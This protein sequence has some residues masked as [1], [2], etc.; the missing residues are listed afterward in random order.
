MDTPLHALIV[1]ASEDDV[2]LIVQ[3]LRRSGYDPIYE[4]IDTAAAMSTALDRQTWDVII[5]DY[6]VLRASGPGALASLQEKG[7]DLPLIVVSSADGEDIAVASIKA[8]AH[9]YV[10]KDNLA[11][12]GAAL[13]RELHEAEGR[14][15]RRRAEQAL[16]QRTAQLEAM[17]E[18]S[19]ELAAQLDLDTLLHSIVSRAIELLGGTSGGLYLYRPEQDALEWSMAVGRTEAFIG[20]VLHRGEGLSGKVWETGEL[21]IVDDYGHWEGRASAYDGV[22]V[23]AAVAAPIRWGDAFLGA[24]NVSSEAVGAFS[25]AHAELLSLL[26]TQAAIAIR[27]AQLYEEAQARSRYLETLQGINAT[28]RST[29]PLKEVLDTIV[30]GAGEALHYVGCLIAI[31]DAAGERLALGAA[32]GT[33]LLSA[34][35]SLTGFKMDAFR[36]PLKTEANPIART[37]LSGELQ[38]WSRVPKEIVLGVVPR[39]SARLAPA[40]ERATGAGLIACVPLRGVAGVVGL[41]IV[42]SPREQLPTEERAMLLG[43]ADQAGLAIDNARLYDE[44]HRRAERLA[45]VNHVARAVGTTL[46]LEDLLE[47]VYQEI[48]LIFQADAFFIALY[49]DKA[50]ELDFRLQID[51][52]IRQA[53][54]R[55]PVGTGLTSLVVAEQKPVLV[56]DLEQEQDRLPQPT[57]WG[58]MK[59]PGSWLGVP[60]KVGER[61]VGVICVQAYRSHAYDGEDQLLLS[62]IADQVAVAVEKARLYQTLHDSEV[63][64]RVL[65]SSIRSPVL[66]LSEDMT[67]LY[68]NDAYAGFVGKS[69]VELEAENLLALFPEFSKMRS[70]AAYMRVLETGEAERVEGAY[71]ERHLRSWVYRTPWGILAIGEDITEQRRAEREIAERQQYLEG[72]LASAPDAIVTLDA[73][74]RIVD[75]SAGAER[76]F[77]YTRDQVFGRNLDHLIT[78]PEVL[79]EATGLTRVVVS[80]EA[81]PP[82][83]AVR[84]RK[85]GSP[86]QVI[87]AGSPIL[88]EGKLIGIVAVYT[89]ISER[90]QA[91]AALRESEEKYRNLF[92]H[93]NDGIFLHD[94]SGNIL[95]A[96]RKALEQLGYTRSEMLAFKIPD[97]HPAEAL[98]ASR[99]AFEKVSKEGFVHFELD[100]RRK[101]GQVFSAE[102]SSGLLEIGDEM[103]VQGIVRDITVRK[104]AERLLKA[105]NEAALAV[106]Q[107]LTPEE[108][109]AAVGEEFKKLGF[110]CAILLTDDDKSRLFPK[111]YSY[112]AKAVRAAERLM[113]V[114]AEHFYIAVDSVDFLRQAVCDKQAVF[115]D[116]EDTLRQVLP[117]PLRTF[118][119]RLVSM[120]KVGKSINVPLIIEDRVS[121]LLSV[122]SDDLTAEDIPAITAFA[123]QMAAAWRKTQ[124]L[125]DLERSLEELKRTQV[126]L[127][128]AQKMEAVGRL[129]GGVAHDFNNM[130]TVIQ[131]GTQLI[132]R[133]LHPDDPLWEYVRQIEEAS[134]RATALTKQLLIFSRREIVEPQVENLNEVVSNLSRMLR[135]II[136]EDIELLTALAEDLWPVK[137]DPSQVEQVIVNLAVNARDAMP[138]GGRLAIETANVVL[139]E[140]YAAHHLDVEPGEYVMLTVGDTGVGMSDEIKAHLF[141]PFFTTKERGKGTGLGLATVFG[142]IKQHGG[143]IWVY[144]EVGQ[145]TL[146]KIYL[147]RVGESESPSAVPSLRLPASTTQG[148]ETI[149]VVEDDVTVRNLAMRILDAHGYRVL[150]AGNGPEAIQTSQG[151][152]G[153]IHLVLTDVVMPQM[154][155]RVLA[156]QLQSQRP[157][158]RVLYMSGYS[159][160]LIAHHG[161]LEEGVA[162]LLKPFTM[163]TLLQKVRMVLD[164]PT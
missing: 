100:F 3:E 71:D 56:R 163:D 147:P 46:H 82:R 142:I 153:P 5:A 51:E 121:G 40:I 14:R 78:N 18:V 49:D 41:L 89:D 24:L 52:G 65:L 12:L 8:G 87:V 99:A 7:L 53:P 107:A 17:Q 156:E 152:K 70:F 22:H 137:V 29:L 38:A 25:S 133:Q 27:N 55:Q 140:T 37:Y 145:G 161:V 130:L 63:K 16:R 127:L 21:L 32:W 93:S 61:L 125:Q 119:G 122:Q 23:G 20:S 77:G 44:A 158:M 66:A 136:G 114:N 154:N 150:A 105:L 97:L 64:H 10:L 90:K 151:H 104:R 84:C 103:V 92:H 88:V 101:N 28:L 34:A 146:F 81:V 128:Q 2:L 162:L 15:A 47:R 98:A 58:T 68:C 50:S 74:H 69:A 30:R 135:R 116:G 13:R 26:T 109:F 124:L 148:T 112:D 54:V 59:L 106:E 134:E 86:V 102:V 94:L 160:D 96:N 144:S 75:W 155:G 139:D 9:D 33:R 83:E 143:H 1:E 31:P 60:M 157:A 43:L 72:V 6:S 42:F 19:L 91:E 159:D 126:Q 113:S 95:D 117:A 123:H 85:D 131:F 111:Y 164:A 141:E 45:V 57:L 4:R 149:L 108:A 132:E 118:A 120:L 11:R 39:I 73:Q 48:A 67:I 115:A 76:L 129:A 110:S 80:G 36:L 79:E 35:A 138:Q 62:T